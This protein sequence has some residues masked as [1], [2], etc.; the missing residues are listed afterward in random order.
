LDE[1]WFGLL[2]LHTGHFVSTSRHRTGSTAAAH[3]KFIEKN[4]PPIWM[5]EN[6]K[7]LHAK[8]KDPY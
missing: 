8:D 5:A 7:N 1:P 2:C 4:L 6:V 3:L